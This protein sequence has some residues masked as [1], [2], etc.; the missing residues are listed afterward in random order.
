MSSSGSK[1]HDDCPELE[2]QFFYSSPLP[3]DDPLSVVPT[4]NGSESKSVKHPLRPFSAYDNDSLEEAWRGFAS[5]KDNKHQKKLNDSTDGKLLKLREN[6]STGQASQYVIDPQSSK[7]ST[8]QK[9]SQSVQDPKSRKHPHASTGSE[10]E[11][12]SKAVR[13]SQS[14]TKSYGSTVLSRGAFGDSD[15]VKGSPDG[16]NPHSEVDEDREQSDKS[17]GDIVNKDKYGANKKHARLS[18]GD[19]ADERLPKEHLKAS[20]ESQTSGHRAFRKY[21]PLKGHEDFEKHLKIEHGRDHSDPHG[22]ESSSM[23]PKL[24]LPPGS[25]DGEDDVGISGKPFVKLPSR[26]SSPQRQPL[27][28]SNHDDAESQMPVA[29]SAGKYPSDLLD[30]DGPAYGET[31]DMHVHDCKAHKNTKKHADVPVGISRLHLVKLPALH[32][33]PIYWSPVHDEASVTRGTWFYKNTM[34]PVEPA[35]ANQLES[36]YRELGCWSETWNDELRSAMEVG[37]AGE[38]KIAHRLW[39]KE[40]DART[41]SRKSMYPHLSTNPYCAAICFHGEAA[42]EGSIVPG[43]KSSES[44]VLAKKYSNAQVIYKDAQNAFILKPNL[45]PSAYYGRKPLQKIMKGATVGIHVVR[46]FDWKSW[47]KIHPSKKTDAVTKVEENAPVAGDADA[48]S[49]NFCP[50][51]RSQEKQPKVTDLCLVVHGIGQKLSERMESFHF[52]HAMNAFRRSVTAERGN[53]AVKNVL[54]KSLGGIMVLPVNWRSNLSFEGEDPVKD[55]GEDR[56]Q[57][58]FSLND[59]TQPTIPAVR[60]LISDVMLDIPYYLS[61]HKSKMIQAV[62]SEAN[63]VYRLWCKNNPDFQRGGRVHIIAHSLGSVMAVEILSKQPTSVPKVDVHSRRIDVKHF[64]FNTTNLFCAGSPAGF[65]FYLEKAKLLPRRGQGKPDAEHR[66][67][68]DKKITGESGTFGCMAVDNVYNI[69]H[70]NDPIAYRLNATVDAQY[71]SSLRNAQVPSATTGFFESIGHAMRSMIPGV[72]ASADTCVGEVSRPGNIARLPSQLELEV[73]DFTREEIAEKKFCLLNDNGQVD[74]CLSSG[75]GPLEIQY[76]NMLGAHS[77]YWISPG[78]VRMIVTE[79]GR[80]PGRSSTL[81]NMRA[82]KVGH[83]A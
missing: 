10:Q 79:V 72:S 69:M 30:T 42:A 74:W 48:A 32:M 83:K 19:G 46:G 24:Y 44:K 43:E 77:S 15:A 37:A 53:D 1:G 5:G 55:D 57:S 82:T 41:S 12:A 76:I 80:E 56:H 50:A 20:S 39:P 29:E 35:V 23:T 75:G 11:P 81:P 14:I 66:D 40:T 36:G 13:G 58:D 49:S 28:F 51:C 6:T 65:F 31:E 9:A 17:I 73:H 61:R 70:Y 67:E 52:T 45:Q 33:Q 21:E 3:I 38:E 7:G 60:T 54:R 2:A 18:Q 26:R 59:I 34:L 62:I 27:R 78:F 25:L 4:P 22:S 63:R 71:A 47:E 8:P 68:L 16:T 64:D